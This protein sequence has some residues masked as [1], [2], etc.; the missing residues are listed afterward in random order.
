MSRGRPAAARPP[1]GLW[2]WRAMAL[3]FAAALVSGCGSGTGRG[4]LSL[5]DPPGVTLSGES[6]LQLA[7]RSCGGDPELSKLEETPTEVR[8]EVVADTDDGPTC[9]AAEELEVELEEPLAD[10]RVVD[11]VSGEVLEVE[12]RS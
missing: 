6:L 7:L 9:A 3:L 4:P 5:A 1:S 8:I 2:W 12:R 10:R 11:L